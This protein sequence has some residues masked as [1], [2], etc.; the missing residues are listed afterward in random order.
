MEKN[1]KNFQQE[2]TTI[3]LVEL[4]SALW[5]KAHII[6]LVG[7]VFGLLAFIG[8]KTLMT[9][10]YESV[11]K[12]YVI[13]KQNEN[14]VTASD[15][16]TGTQLTKDY[17]ELVK[18]RPVLEEVIAK[19][20]LDMTTKELAESISVETPADTR[21]LKITTTNEDPKMAKDIADEVRKA[22]SVQ[23]QKVMNIDAV[24][25]VE[26]ANLPELP[27]SPSSS[28]NAV[29][30]VLL[31]MILTAVVVVVMF[32]LNDTI[33]TSDDVKKYLDLNVL[34]VLPIQ[35]GTNSKT[36]GKKQNQKNAAGN[37]RG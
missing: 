5:K 15:L 27:A 2:E 7:I 34:A 32:L 1:Q 18:S 29:L 3:N 11:T 9:P 26:E 13:T 8:T 19:L 4:F 28:K 17:M 37:K 16:Q 21:I 14:T 25:T 24:N 10:M 35:E 30:G 36:A 12:A 33:K 31:G 22:M 20:D 6:V 23:I